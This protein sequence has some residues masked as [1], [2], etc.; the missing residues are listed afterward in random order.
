MFTLHVLQG[1]PVGVEVLVV[2]PRET[3]MALPS[4]ELLLRWGLRY[5]VVLEKNT[6]TNVANFPRHLSRSESTLILARPV[7]YAAPM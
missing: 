2:G 1:L 3:R 4:V 6:D 7:T 5:N